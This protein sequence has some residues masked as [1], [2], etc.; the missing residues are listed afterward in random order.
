MALINDDTESDIPILAKFAFDPL[1]SSVCS[2]RAVL[3]ILALKRESD[4]H[5]C[6]LTKFLDRS[7]SVFFI[8]YVAS[9]ALLKLRA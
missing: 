5:R 2:L 9:V 4:F 3:L 1:F 7:E 6:I 8:F